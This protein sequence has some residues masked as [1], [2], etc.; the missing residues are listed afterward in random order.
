[1]TERDPNLL[2]MTRSYDPNVD[3]PLRIQR[4][5]G[6]STRYEYFGCNTIN[7]YCGDSLLRLMVETRERNAADTSTISYKRVYTDSLGRPKYEQAQSFDG[8]LATVQSMYDARGNLASQS[9]PYF[10]GTN[11]YRG[12]SYTYDLLNR[13]TQT[14]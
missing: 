14:Q 13:V 7:N 11:Q 1:L 10:A 3:R 6:T 9:T 8:G 4:P 2:T 5:D 12:S